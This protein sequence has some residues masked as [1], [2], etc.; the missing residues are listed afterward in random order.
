MN[1]LRSP[2]TGA[3]VRVD[4]VDAVSSV[5]TGLRQTLVY[6]FA[7]VDSMISR[8]ALTA[9]SSQVIG[10]GGS[11]LAWIRLALVHLLMTVA[12]HVSGLTSA[13]VCVTHINTLTRVTAQNGHRHSLLLGGDLTADTGDVAVD[14]RPATGTLAGER[15]PLLPTRATVLTGGRVTPAHQTLAVESAVSVWAGAFVGAVSILTGT[16]VLTRP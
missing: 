3:F 11:V 8:N 16:S 13:Q 15:R 5:L 2:R 10:A 12:A 9:V 14:A 1:T 4:E 6:L 7:A